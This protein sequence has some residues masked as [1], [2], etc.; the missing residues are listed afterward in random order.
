LLSLPPSRRTTTTDRSSHTNI[1]STR[2]INRTKHSGPIVTAVSAM[3]KGATGRESTDAVSSF[4][5]CA[6]IDAGRAG[7]AGLETVSHVWPVQLLLVQAPLAQAPVAHYLACQFLYLGKKSCEKG[8]RL[9]TFPH[10]PLFKAS[11]NKS[12]IHDCD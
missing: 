9:T 3:V 4:F 7:A 11:V 12:A 8:L 6:G 2:R 10:P 1:H 5:R